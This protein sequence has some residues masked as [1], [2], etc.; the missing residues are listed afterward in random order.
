MLTEDDID[1]FI[2]LDSELMICANIGGMVPLSANMGQAM[3]HF[4]ISDTNKQM[5]LN[6]KGFIPHLVHA[7]LLEGSPEHARKDTPEEIKAAVQR[8]FAE[9]I[10]Q[11]SLFPPGCEA[12]RA[13]DITEVLDQLVDKA[14]SEEAK[15][16]ARG[17]LMQLTDRHREVPTVVDPDAR[18]VMLSCERD[19][20]VVAMDIF[21]DGLTH[22]VLCCAVLCCAVLCCAVLCCRRR[23]MGCP[24][25]REE[26]RG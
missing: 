23:P 13:A 3:L 10:Q 16:S 19:S 18:H 1:G 4:C 2:K 17:A 15:D 24:G 12:L 14:W 8:D 26:D 9:C 20:S 6:N 5:L 22:R 11:V 21:I 7:L 25:Y